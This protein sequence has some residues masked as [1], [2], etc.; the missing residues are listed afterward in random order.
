M[1]NRHQ[2]AMTD[3]HVTCAGAGR[4]F[5][6]GHCSHKGSG[7]RGGFSQFAGNRIP[8]T[9]R[10]VDINLIVFVAKITIIIHHPHVNKI[11]GPYL[12]R[13]SLDRL[14][15]IPILFFR[16][17]GQLLRYCFS[18][19]LLDFSAGSLEC[20]VR[21]DPDAVKLGQFRIEFLFE[22]V[23]VIHMDFI[24]AGDLQDPVPNRW[25]IQ[26]RRNFSG[27]Q[28]LASTAACQ[29]QLLRIATR[30][31]RDID[32]DLQIAATDA[33]VT[34]V[35]HD[36]K[37]M[38]GRV[39]ALGSLPQSADRAEHVQLCEKTLLDS[40]NLGQ[41]VE[42]LVGQLGTWRALQNGLK[43]L[44]PHVEFALSNCHHTH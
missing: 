39:P 31:C 44:P 24:G 36:K 27:E 32:R 9:R 7:V 13:I 5:S 29:H 38:T 20:G 11:T 35:N 25:L 23:R 12:V 37:R 22:I 17:A 4:H 21:C 40:I 19:L 18:F 3:R 42:C 10:Q 30:V 33:E 43:Q 8:I 14:A 26:Q 16:V 34:V 28:A 41:V 15:K 6:G 2:R 1:I